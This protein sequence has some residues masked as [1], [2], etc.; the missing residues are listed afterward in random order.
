MFSH[1]VAINAVVSALA[2][3]PRVLHFRPDHTS[4]T[5]LETDGERLTLVAKGREAT[6]GVL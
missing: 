2:G 6:T 4:I 3:D 1:Y 5:V